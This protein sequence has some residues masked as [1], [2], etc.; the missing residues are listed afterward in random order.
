[1]ESLPSE[2]TCNPAGHRRPVCLSFDVAR[3]K[4]GFIDYPKIVTNDG[5]ASSG[6]NQCM[7]VPLNEV[8]RPEI[9]VELENQQD[10]RHEAA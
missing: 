7:A 8:N 6:A 1:M 2:V 3:N 4:W 9:H 5:V 10:A